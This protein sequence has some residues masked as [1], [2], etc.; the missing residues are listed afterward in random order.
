MPRSDPIRSRG[1]RRSVDLRLFYAYGRSSQA[2]GSFRGPRNGR[3]GSVGLINYRK[4]R[5]DFRMKLGVTMN[6]TKRQKEIL[7]FIRSYRSR[8]GHLAH[9]ARDSRAVRSL[10][11]RHGPEAP[12]AA[13]GEGRPVAGVEP[14]PRHRAVRARR[15]PARSP[16]SVSW[17]PGGRSSRSRTKRRSRCRLRCSARASTSFCACGATR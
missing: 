13:R 15:R 4:D 9:A 2:D 1:R 8:A 14:Q 17:P 10:L 3:D 12:E 5:C 11:L 16:F 7:D 6:L